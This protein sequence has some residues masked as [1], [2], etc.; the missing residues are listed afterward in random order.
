M[1]PVEAAIRA[2][3]HAMGADPNTWRGFE[4]IGRT[5]IDAFIAALPPDLAAA[6]QHALGSGAD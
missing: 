1:N 5:A 3:C 4:E 2:A 6:V